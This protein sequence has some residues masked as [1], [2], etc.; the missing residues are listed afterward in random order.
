MKFI[1]PPIPKASGGR[2]DHCDYCPKR[3]G[4]ECALGCANEV[5]KVTSERDKDGVVVVGPF[6]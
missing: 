3:K 5:S 4:E 2:Y 6:S 1:P